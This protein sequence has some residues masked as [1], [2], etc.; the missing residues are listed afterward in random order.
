[1]AVTAN[2]TTGQVLTAST[3]NDYMINSGLVYVTS[4]TVG[5]G[6]SSVTVSSAFS[7]TYDNYKI[8]CSGGVMS[9]VADISLR[10]GST[11]TNYYGSFIYC[12][13]NSN[14]VQGVG[15]NNSSSMPYIGS[16]DTAY[17]EV[18]IDLLSPYL[19]KP[20]VQNGVFHGNLAIGSSSYRL[21]DTTSYTAFTLTASTGTFTGGTVTVY[22]YRKA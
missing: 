11:S 18:N 2:L 1:M 3:V 19:T 8:I 16:G 21:N 13:Y 9:T 4:A 10:L 14:T 5:S 15:T 12:A 6:V 20:T 17:Y 7:S 22:G